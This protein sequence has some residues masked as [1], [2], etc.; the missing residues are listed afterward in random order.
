MH[1]ELEAVVA[2]SD[3]V[4]WHLRGGAEGNHEEP[5]Y[6]LCRGRDS[7]QVSPEHK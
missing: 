5:R 1:N 3:I 6:I 7:N 4:S 2:S